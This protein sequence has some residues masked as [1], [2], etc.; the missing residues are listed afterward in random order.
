MTDTAYARRLQEVASAA[1]AIEEF[2]AGRMLLLPATS[3][4]APSTDADLTNVLRNTGMLIALASIA[5]LPSVT[6]PQIE[7]E[8]AQ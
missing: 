7:S 2:M 6:V 5:G 3:S 8:R 1:T 4:T